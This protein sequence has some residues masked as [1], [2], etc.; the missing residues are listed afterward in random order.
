MTFSQCSGVSTLLEMLTYRRPASSK[1]E[2]RFIREHIFPLGMSID[3]AGNVYKRIGDAPVLWSCHTDT[4]HRA[5]GQ[6]LVTVQDGYAM[7]PKD[8]LS[9]CL[10]ADDT[11]GVWLMREMILAERPGLYVFHRGEEIGGVGS[12][13]VA[14]KGSRLLEGTLCAIALDRAGTNDVITHQGGRCCSDTFA[15]RLADKLGMGFRPDDS[16]VFTDT[17][18]YVDHIGEC[19]N[20]SVGYYKQHRTEECLDIPFLLSLRDRLLEIDTA[21]LPIVRKPGE[22]DAYDFGGWADRYSDFTDY[23]S[24]FDQ[25]TMSDLVRSHP[26][27]IADLLIDYGFDMKE[28]LREL[29]Q[30]GVIQ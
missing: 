13:H 9:N 2:R 8:S 29:G 1:T 6:Q 10:G 28:L 18:N 20:L 3:D 17:A 21:D 4:V 24:W 25:G 5:G 19:T 12:S 7:L 30:R 15:Q 26:E 14:R 11:A 22:A 27:E 23:R 16:G